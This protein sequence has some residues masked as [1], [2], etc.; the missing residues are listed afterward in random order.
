ME[1]GS[2]YGCLTVLECSEK[3]IKCQCRCG[4]IH[5][6]DTK[7]VEANPKYCRYPM[8]IS[9][10]MTYSITA[11]NATYNKKKKY[12]DLMNVVFV[13]KRTD[14]NPS[15]EYC[16]LWN[17]YKQ[18]QKKVTSSDEKQYT[19]KVWKEKNKKYVTYDIY[20]ASHLEAL[21]KLYPNDHFE[22]CPQSDIRNH[23]MIIG[24]DYEFEVSNHFG[25]SA[26]NRSRRYRRV[27]N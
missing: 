24:H 25:N 23:T 19:V 27:K 4:K 11:Q 14:C 9:T 12:G 16:G 17:N 21:K 3:L 18:K 13:D 2:K 20:A 10:R 6:Y 22:L 8:F 7:T 15:D 26:Q 5:Y 1:I